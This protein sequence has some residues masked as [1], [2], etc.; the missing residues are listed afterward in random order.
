MKRMESLNKKGQ[1]FDNLGA[2]AVGIAGLA[3]TLVITFLIISK[4]RSNISSTAGTYCANAN[5]Y[6]NGSNCCAEG[7]LVCSGVNVTGVSVA[8]NATNTMGS[9]V[10][11]IPGWVSLIVIAVIG[12]VI[13]GLVALFRR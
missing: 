2:L 1:V 9:A 6:I 4:S 5:D 10:S 12:S 13:L 8:Y 11:E 7:S 3:I